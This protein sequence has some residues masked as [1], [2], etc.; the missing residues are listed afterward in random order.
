[1]EWTLKL[2]KRRYVKHF[3]GEAHLTT[4]KH[5]AP[6][7]RKTHHISVA[8]IIIIIMDITSWTVPVTMINTANLFFS[9]CPWHVL[10]FHL[11]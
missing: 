5:L 4:C 9:G 7:S 6:V 2:A 3:M 8:K 1:M 11:F 10:T